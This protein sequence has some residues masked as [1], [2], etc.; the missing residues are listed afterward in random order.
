MSILDAIICTKK[1]EI[2]RQKKV[3]GT[4][5][6]VK[7][8]YYSRN[9]HS[10]KASLLKEGSS[11]II[12]EFKQKSPSKGEINP[13]ARVET[14]TKGYAAAG[15]AGLSVLTDFEYFGGTLVN[16]LKAR[17]TN[18]GMPLLRKDFIIDAYQ[19]TEAKAY[20]ADVILLI[21]ACL[22]GKKVAALAGKAREL[23]MEV[24]LEIH[25]PEELDRV[26]PLVDLVGVNNRDLNSFGVSVDTSLKLANL[27]PADFVKISESGISDPVTVRLLREAGYKGFLIGETFMKTADPA[28]ACR[29]FIAS[30]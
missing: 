11:G 6:L 16:L 1:G 10:L 17:E 24:L 13:G 23:G 20:G 25:G 8:P 30:L 14:V 3:T 29:E 27:I 19:V 12:A 5:Q 2:D 9:C 28:A 18:P 7:M 21:A 26:S 15:A 22:S 4:S